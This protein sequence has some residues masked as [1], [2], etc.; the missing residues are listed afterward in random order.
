MTFMEL[1]MYT[2]IALL[3][4]VIGLGI[5]MFIIYK[6]MR[7]L[8]QGSSAQ[9]LESIII[10]TNTYLK[11]LG[12]HHK[13]LVKDVRDLEEDAQHNIQHVGIVRFNPFKETGGNQSFAVAFTDKQKS[14][15]VLSS[16]YARDRVNIFA[17]PVVNGSSEYQLTKEEQAALLSSYK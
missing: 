10:E 1:L 8:T 7:A 14:G 12:S 17:K 3:V 5:L 15:M 6:R 16:L 2:T 11:Q 13:Q 9:S 4:C